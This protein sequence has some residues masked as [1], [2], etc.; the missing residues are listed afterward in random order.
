M[1]AFSRWGF[2]VLKE[3][4]SLAANGVTLKSV[5]GA[6]WVYAS[7]TNVPAS[8]FQYHVAPPTLPFAAFLVS[9]FW[10]QAANQWAALSN[11]RQLHEDV[12]M[13]QE[14]LHA[15]FVKEVREC[16]NHLDEHES[17]RPV[18]SVCYDLVVPIT[19]KDGGISVK[20]AKNLKGVSGVCLCAAV[21]F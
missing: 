16:S 7:S 19:K 3:D 21:I 1:F 5:W 2:F 18:N 13:E 10:G 8:M 14:S 4:A 12:I 9:H 11:L 6:R 20:R 17:G 15:D